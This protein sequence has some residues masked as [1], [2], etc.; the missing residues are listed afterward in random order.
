MGRQ[1]HKLPLLCSGNGARGAKTGT[2]GENS[3]KH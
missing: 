2:W 3:R 1:N